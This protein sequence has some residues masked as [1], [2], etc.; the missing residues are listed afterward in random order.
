MTEIAEVIGLRQM[1]P[2]VETVL[3]LNQAVETHKLR[4]SRHTRG[5]IVSQ[6]KV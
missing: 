4:Q 3:P 2:S 1:R 6:V 5:K